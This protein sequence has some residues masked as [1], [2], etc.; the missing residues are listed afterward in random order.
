MEHRLQGKRFENDYTVEELE[1]I[2]E[3]ITSTVTVPVNV[4]IKADHHVLDLSRM[5]ELLREANLIVFQNCGCRVNR[6]NCDAP[7]DVCL[8]LD[9]AGE[10]ELK[11]E[12]YG[13]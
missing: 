4:S 8:T 7:L 1:E 10:Q 11:S 2:F 12:R 6:E 9:D 5:E 13:S 3:D